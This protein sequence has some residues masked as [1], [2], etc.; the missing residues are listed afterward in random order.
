MQLHHL[1]FEV[2]DTAV[3]R[4]GQLREQR[5]VVEADA[6]RVTSMFVMQIAGYLNQVVQFMYQR[7]NVARLGVAAGARRACR[8]FFAFAAGSQRGCGSRERGDG[9]GEQQTAFAAGCLFGERVGGF[10]G[11]TSNV[12]AEGEEGDIGGHAED[13][14]R[15]QDHPGRVDGYRQG[16]IDDG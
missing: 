16:E 8:A 4:G 9:S 11:G 1:V 5:G 13:Q 10:M 2:S 6:G 15:R 3:T 12:F 7:V 14:R